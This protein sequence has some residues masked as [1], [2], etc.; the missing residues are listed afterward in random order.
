MVRLSDVWMVGG[1]V[2]LSENRGQK[3]T[4]RVPS[5][6]PHMVFQGWGSGWR[7]GVWG[8]VKHVALRM[9]MDRGR[10]RTWLRIDWCRDRWKEKRKYE[11]KRKGKKRSQ[12][13]GHGKVP[14]SGLTVIL[15]LMEGR[16]AGMAMMSSL[17]TQMVD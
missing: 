4:S 10:E 1:T 2:S 14:I 5:G 6:T 16:I 8:S 11:M 12:P 3:G 9:Q 15:R 13:N 7:C 17:G